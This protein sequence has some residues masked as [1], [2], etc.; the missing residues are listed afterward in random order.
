MRSQFLA[1][2]NYFKSAARRR[3]FNRAS[4]YALS[5]VILVSTLVVLLPVA[6]EFPPRSTVPPQQQASTG[7][8]IPMFG[9]SKAEVDQ[10]TNAKLAHPIVPFMVVINPD[11]GPGRSYDPFYATAVSQMQTAGITVLGYVTS[12]WGEGNLSMI[13]GEILSYHRW[14]GVDGIYIDEMAN[15]EFSST[16][17]YLPSYYAAITQYA[18]SLGMARVI[19]NSGADVPYYFI[20][21]VDIIG[22]FENPFV[23]P[24]DWLGGYMINMHG[25]HSGYNRSNFWWVGYNVTSFN[26]YYLLAASNYAGYIFLT[27]GRIPQPYGVLPVYFD[28]LVSRLASIVR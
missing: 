9:Y 26:P 23:P 27:D 6:G 17:V 28:E 22:V 24:L 2:K 13:K 12:S 20:G 10:I 8:L 7:I 1:S 18:K 3:R 16:E 14:Y 19:G 11:S 4:A 15:W 5:T 21:S 25:W